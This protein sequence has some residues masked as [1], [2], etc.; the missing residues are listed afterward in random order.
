MM[1]IERIQMEFLGIKKVKY[2]GFQII[3]EATLLD[4]LVLEHLSTIILFL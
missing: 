4:A 1:V 3:A 2:F